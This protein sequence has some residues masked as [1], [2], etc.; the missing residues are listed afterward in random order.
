M[1]IRERLDALEASM[2]DENDR[3]VEEYRDRYPE[4]V[5]AIDALRAVAEV[6]DEMDQVDLFAAYAF[7]LR[8]AIE[9]G[10]KS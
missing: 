3:S 9:K 8:K 4:H 5:R 6:L 1:S 2:A 10:L 7:R